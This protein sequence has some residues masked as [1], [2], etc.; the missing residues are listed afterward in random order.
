MENAASK[1]PTQSKQMLIAFKTVIK[2]F[3][4]V[5]DPKRWNGDGNLLDWWDTRT[6]AM[7]NLVPP[8]A[9]VLEFGA[10]KRVLEKNLKDYKKYTPS[11]IVGRGEDTLILDL[12]AKVLPSFSGYDTAV[13][14]GVLEY[15]YNVPRLI[16]HLQTYFPM[17]ITSYAVNQENENIF[18]RRGRG[19]VNDYSTDAFINIFLKYG[20]TLNGIEK[21]YSQKIFT[22]TL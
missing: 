1:W 9:A 13:F 11:D 7:A 16:S 21:W 15:V 19:W 5:S 12:N 3:W 14:S 22:F 20:Y 6:M 8:G 18:K 17:I 10:G 2:K 4:K